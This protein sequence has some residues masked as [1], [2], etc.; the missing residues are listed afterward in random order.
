[1]VSRPIKNCYWVAPGKL[2][3]GEYPIDLEEKTS[4]AKMSSLIDAGVSVFIDLTEKNEMAWESP[5][6]SYASLLGPARHQRFAIRDRSIPETPEHTTAILDAIDLHIGEG[7]TVYVHCWGGVG[8]T[9]TIVGCWLARRGHEGRDALDRLNQLWQC[10]PK[11]EVRTAPETHEQAQ[12][13]LNWRE[14]PR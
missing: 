14:P 2:L 6:R 12:Y 1:M 5:L 13:I 11:S 4:Q 8:R 7:S 9:G 3:A 10:C